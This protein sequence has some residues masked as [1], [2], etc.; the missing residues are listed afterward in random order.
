MRDS[1]IQYIKV[2]A[3]AE[4]QLRNETGGSDKLICVPMVGLM[5][6]AKLLHRIASDRPLHPK[7]RAPLYH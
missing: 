6:A 5:C 3:N 1:N 2:N 7:S 4:L